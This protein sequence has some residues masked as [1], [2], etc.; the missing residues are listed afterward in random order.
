MKFESDLL[1]GASYAEAVAYIEARD[2]WAEVLGI[3][4]DAF[5]V[6]VKIYH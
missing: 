2:L 1:V 4:C 3:E 5:G 6:V